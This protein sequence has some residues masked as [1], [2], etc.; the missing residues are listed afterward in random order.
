MLRHMLRPRTVSGPP[1]AVPGLPADRTR[2][3]ADFYP[4]PPHIRG[5][6]SKGPR[7]PKAREG[8]FHFF[9]FC[10][11]GPPWARRRQPYRICGICGMGGTSLAAISGNI[12]QIFEQIAASPLLPVLQGTR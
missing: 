1:R 8:S 5:P 11:R 4:P 6:Q 10:P 12:V 7:G 3:P 9:Y 2:A